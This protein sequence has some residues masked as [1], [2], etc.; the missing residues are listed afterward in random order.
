MKAYLGM[1][2]SSNVYLQ[3]KLTTRRFG[4]IHKVGILLGKSFF[5]TVVNMLLFSLT[6][7]AP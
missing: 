4:S 5:K 7:T 2:S 1:E 3:L 6:V